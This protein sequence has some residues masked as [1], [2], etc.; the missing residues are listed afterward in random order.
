MQPEY[1]PQQ[2]YPS[3]PVSSDEIYASALQEERVRNIIAQTSPDN[4]LAEVEWR[5]RGY[6][7]NIAIG[8]WERIDPNVPEPSPL[9]VSRYIS[10]LGSMLNDNTRFTNLSSSQ[11]NRLMVLCIEWLADDLNSNAV[12]YG[13][14]DNYTERTRI[15]YIILN[16]TFFVLKRAEN[17][18]ESRRIWSALQVSENLSQQPQKKSLLDSLKFW[19]SE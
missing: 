12:E 8:Q 14:G 3:E 10:F 13:L 16:A 2:Y 6:R 17:G 15:G 11:I 9:L 19:R 1:M 4:Q 18:M 7:K 5:I